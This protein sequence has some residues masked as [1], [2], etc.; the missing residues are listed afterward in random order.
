MVYLTVFDYCDTSLT[1]LPISSL[2]PITSTKTWYISRSLTIVT[3]LLQI[4]LFPSYHSVGRTIAQSVQHE[5]FM[6]T[7]LIPLDNPV[8]VGQKMHRA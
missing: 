5:F 6:S 1:D 7:L 8:S 2:S 4:Y 3:H